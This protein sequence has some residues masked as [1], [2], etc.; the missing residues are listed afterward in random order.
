MHIDAGVPSER[1]PLS[2]ASGY[3]GVGA[4]IDIYPDGKDAAPLIGEVKGRADGS[5]WKI[6]SRWLGINDLL[7]L[8]KDREP[9]LIVM[10]WPVHIRLIGKRR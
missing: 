8:V 3:Q 5:G 1:I 4:D 2:G 10:P 7:F 6:I 9:P